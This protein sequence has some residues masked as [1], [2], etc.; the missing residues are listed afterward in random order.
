MKVERT[1]MSGQS[2]RQ[3]CTRSRV[4]STAPGRFISLRMRGLACWNGISRYGRIRFSAIS[5]TI[6][7]TCGYGYT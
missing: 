2:W 6:S 1:V 3:R 5:G 7:S 4:L